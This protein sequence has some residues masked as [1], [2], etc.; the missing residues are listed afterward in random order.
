MKITQ[1]TTFRT[2]WGSLFVRV[3]TEIEFVDSCLVVPQTHG[4]GLKVDEAPMRA[5][6]VEIH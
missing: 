4:L 5:T 3:E 2:A 1:V 6:T